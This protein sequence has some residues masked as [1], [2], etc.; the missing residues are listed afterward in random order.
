MVIT[1]VRLSQLI[2]HTEV[3]SKLIEAYISFCLVSLSL[4]LYIPHMHSNFQEAFR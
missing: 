2:N 1:V 3:Y 4:S